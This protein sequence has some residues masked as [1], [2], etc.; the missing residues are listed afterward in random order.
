MLELYNIFWVIPGVIFV[1]IYNRRR[2]ERAI[3]LSGWPYIF[4]LVLIAALTW[5]PAEWIALKFLYNQDIETYSA[6]KILSQKL[7]ILLISIA[8]SIIL[9]LLVQIEY[10]GKM[11]LPPIYDSFY[12]KCVEW[13][14]EIVL[15]TLKNGKAYIGILW[16]YPENPRDRYESQNI[17]IIPIQSGYREEVKKRINWTTYYPYK[18]PNFKDVEVMIPRSE[19]ITF[20][21]FNVEAYQYFESLKK[22]L[23]N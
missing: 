20:G 19:I 11:F 9:F 3:N 23:N 18:K 12:K 5:F 2:P 16:I 13:E 15:L 10:I 6:L 7:I 8:L 14:K 17:S 1:S 22:N 21:K 4:A